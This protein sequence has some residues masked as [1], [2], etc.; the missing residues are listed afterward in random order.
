MNTRQIQRLVQRVWDVEGYPDYFFSNDR[1]LYRVTS[2][3][4]VK[5]NPR[6]L[7]RY[8]VGYTLKSRFFSLSQ[9]RALLRRHVPTNHPMGF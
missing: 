4:E 2:R 5:M 9:L 3:G 8:T 1:Q 7:K 6:R